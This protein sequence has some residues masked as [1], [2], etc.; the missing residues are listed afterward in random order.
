MLQKVI[1][2]RKFIFIIPS[3]L[4]LIAII[5]AF[6]NR[7]DHPMSRDLHGNYEL[8]EYS[9]NYLKKKGYKNVKT[10]IVLSGDGTAKLLGFP[11]VWR[12][13]GKS[14]GKLIDAD[15]TWELEDGKW[16]IIFF[17]RWK[18]SKESYYS[19]ADVSSEGSEYTI[20]FLIGD[21][22]EYQGLIFK[23]IR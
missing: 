3:I 9:R 20:R 22:D 18:D 7:D 5:S 21:P 2:R 10:R 4:L 15:A 12:G 23:K 1:M 17:L 11:D 13:L 19:S 8:N 14:K 6:A 16:K